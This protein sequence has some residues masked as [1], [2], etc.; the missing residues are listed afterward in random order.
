MTNDLCTDCRDAH[1]LTDAER[2]MRL[3]SACYADLLEAEG[4]R[5]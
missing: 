5:G 3:C 4:G 1:L 2:S